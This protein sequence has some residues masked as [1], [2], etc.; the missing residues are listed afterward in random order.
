V[1]AGTRGQFYPK[2]SRLI[3]KA[4]EQNADSSYT[5]SPAKDMAL[6]SAETWRHEGKRHINDI[7]S[8]EYANF[9]QYCLPKT[10]ILVE[11]SDANSQEMLL[12]A[13]EELNNV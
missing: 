13:V 12:A 6:K 4:I 10:A 8:A 9:R 1:L 2:Q 7:E 3:K 11:I 5:N